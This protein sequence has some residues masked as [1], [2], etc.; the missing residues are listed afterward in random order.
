MKY[1]KLYEDLE[2]FEETWIQEEPEEEIKVGDI[3]TPISYKNVFFYDDRLNTYIGR[4]GIVIS[5]Y[6]DNN[7]KKS[8]YG[9]WY[10]NERV[11][12][13]GILNGINIIAFQ[14]RWPVYKA[15]CFKKKLN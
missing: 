8:E 2:G 4:D 7:W 15:S 11:Y 13:V 12:K 9:V 14:D 1:I 6:N 10:K 5:Y 3:V